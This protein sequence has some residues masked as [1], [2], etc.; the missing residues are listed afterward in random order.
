MPNVS[1]KNLSRGWLGYGVVMALAGAVAGGVWWKSGLDYQDALDAYQQQSRK[2][3]EESAHSLSLNLGQIYQDMRT[4]SMLP[5]VRKI[6]RHGTTLDEDSRQSIQQLYNNLISNM[7][8]SEIYVVPKDID[9]DK[10]D[11]VTGVNEA[12]ILMFDHLVVGD[13]DTSKAEEPET[14]PEAV[15]IFEYRQLKE[16][17]AWLSE[18]YPSLSRINGLDVPMVSGPEIIT[19][20]NHLFEKTNNDADRSGIMLSVPF[21]GPDKAIKGSV[22]AIILTNA[23]QK[24]FPA[25]SYALVNEGHQ[26]LVR[27]AEMRQEL[28]ES[29]WLKTNKPDPTAF[30]SGVAKIE[31]KDTENPFFLWVSLPPEDFL[32]SADVKAIRKFDQIGYGFAALLLILGSLF[33]WNLQRGVEKAR[34]SARAIEASALEVTRMAEQNAKDKAE[35]DQLRA[36]QIADIATR[37]E[38]SVKGVVGQVGQAI[39]GMLSQTAELGHVANAA[40][41]SATLVASISGE[42]AS[43]AA[44]VSAAASQLSSSIQEIQSQTHQ[45]TAVARSAA[46]KTETAKQ[47]IQSLS[48]KSDKVTEIIGLITGIAAQINLLALNATIEAARAGDAGKGFAIVAG[49][50]K[51][52]ANQ[53]AKATDEIT[54][55]I[56]AIQGATETSVHSVMDILAIIDQVSSSTATVASAVEQQSSVTREIADSTKRS[57]EGA[58]RILGSISNVQNGADR[59]GAAAADMAASAEMLD[60]EFSG[61]RQRVDDFLK[62]IR[63][64]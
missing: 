62:V 13:E 3:L 51:N 44:Q 39:S 19:C 28:V 45:S 46:E 63:A 23:L 52:L 56:A 20:D 15:E 4:I 38:E 8:V 60:Q 36:A 30:Y 64:G 5:S 12:P 47:A 53:V 33:W 54:A 31:T 37:F 25:F 40:R 29:P 61:L 59:T 49:E 57:Q 42:A 21:Y 11:P 58:E 50:V 48:E 34:A 27:S 18:N 41:D 6:D 55:Q 24:L 9:P 2:A 35:Q 7:A 17:Q 1:Q 43:G 26:Y 22:S 10:I 14:G 32:Y 16:H